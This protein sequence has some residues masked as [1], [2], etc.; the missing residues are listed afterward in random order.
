M[1]WGSLW[2]W[3][4]FKDALLSF[5]HQP[6]KWLHVILHGD[7]LQFRV[8]VK[9]TCWVVSNA[10]GFLDHVDKVCDYV[11]VWAF[12]LEKSQAFGLRVVGIASKLVAK[13]SFWSPAKE[14]LRLQS[15]LGCALGWQLVLGSQAGLMWRSRKN[16][17]NCCTIW[18]SHPETTTTCSENQVFK[19]FQRFMIM[20]GQTWDQIVLQGFRTSTGSPKRLF[21]GVL[22]VSPPSQGGVQITWTWLLMSGNKF[23]IYMSAFRCYLQN[24]M[25]GNVLSVYH[26]EID[27]PGTP[28]HQ[29]VRGLHCLVAKSS[30]S[31]ALVL[32]SSFDWNNCSTVDR[33]FRTSNFIAWACHLAW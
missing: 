33:Y 23:Y 4:C 6:R 16:E 26:L 31:S 11:F 9:S 2:K 22:R 19:G 32:A 30:G 8:L 28:P 25:S 14:G 17:K 15:Q 18:K 13:G 12:S 27:I 5:I 3:P 24:Y 21:Q 1:A 20:V 7:F 10:T 29:Q